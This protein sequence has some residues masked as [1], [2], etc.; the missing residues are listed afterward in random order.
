ME[1]ENTILDDHFYEP[2]PKQYTRASKGK[3]LAN[4][5]IDRLCWTALL[6]GFGLLLGMAGEEEALLWLEDI[7]PILDYLLTA[8]IATIYYVLFEYFANGKTLGKIITRT[9][10]LDQFGGKPTF[11]AILG[12]SISRFV[13]FEAFS[14]LGNPDEGWHD[15]WSGTMV[16]ED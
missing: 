14:F 15:K 10:V 12:R 1:N 9:R 3:R 6:F 8:V 16:V 13:P 5:I 4:Y 11:G 2:A 7:N